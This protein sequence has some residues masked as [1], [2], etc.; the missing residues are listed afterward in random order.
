M[1]QLTFAMPS[2]EI[3]CNECADLGV[4]IYNNNTCGRFTVTTF[5]LGLPQEH[6]VLIYDALTG[7]VVFFF[8]IGAQS[9]LL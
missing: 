4:V 8:N 9:Y 1:P 5:H 3:E 6:D 7:L 2:N